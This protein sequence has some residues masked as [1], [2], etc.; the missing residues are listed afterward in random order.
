MDYVEYLSSK[1]YITPDA[2]GY[3]LGTALGRWDA[4]YLYQKRLQERLKQFSETT[5]E[6]APLPAL[7]DL[8]EG[9]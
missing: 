7:K 4:E 9:Y 6:G 5:Q 2:K 1:G 3:R 8:A